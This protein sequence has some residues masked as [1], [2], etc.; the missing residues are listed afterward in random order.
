MTL[1][2][3]QSGIFIE[4]NRNRN[5]YWTKALIPG[6]RVYDEKLIQNGEYREWSIRKSKFA[7]GLAKGIRNIK[8]KKK[9]KVL[10]LGA[11]SGTTVS[12]IS[13]IV[14]SEG[15]VFAVEYAFQMARQLIFFAETRPNIAPILADANKPEMYKDNIVQ[16]D[17]LFQDIAQK[18]Q[19]EIFV[20]N[21]Q[22]LKKGKHAVLAVKSKSIDIAVPTKKM[23]AQVHKELRK[24]GNIIAETRLDPLEKDHCIFVLEKK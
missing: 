22:F 13:D 24:H 14:G 21:L 23:Y 5:T 10:Y 19:V 18:N 3:I 9:D 12:H 16:V 15:M 7:A 1:E 8:I 11:S 17:F 20:K 6:Q 4:R 2:Q